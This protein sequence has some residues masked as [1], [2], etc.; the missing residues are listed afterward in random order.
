MGKYKKMNIKIFYFYN[1]CATWRMV[2]KA[3]LF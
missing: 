2:K 3:M 1:L